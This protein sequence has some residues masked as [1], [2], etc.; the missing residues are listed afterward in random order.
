MYVWDLDWASRQVKLAIMVAF[1]V[2]GPAP[3]MFSG[4]PWNMVAVFS[5]L[6]IHLS[7]PKSWSN[8]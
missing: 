7:E 2:S 1:S 5:T 6:H 3:S 4:L 8:F